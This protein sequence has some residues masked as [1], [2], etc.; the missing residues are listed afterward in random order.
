MFV[1]PMR[2]GKVIPQE[3]WTAVDQMASHPFWSADGS[4][5]Y[6]LPTVPSTEFRNLVRARRFEPASHGP[7]G[8]AFTAMTLTEMVVPASMAGTAPVATHDRIVFVLGDFRG[9]VWMMDL[10]STGQHPRR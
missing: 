6:Y 9:A 1:A 5:L 4:L 7:S 2:V 3:T 8:D 10:E